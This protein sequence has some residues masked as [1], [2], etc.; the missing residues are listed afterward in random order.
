V[1]AWY[2]RALEAGAVSMEAPALQPYGERRAAV[3][4]AFDN[5]SYLAAPAT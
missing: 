5:Q 3:R 2:R 4:D 1:D